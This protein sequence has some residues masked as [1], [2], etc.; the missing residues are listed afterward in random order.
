VSHVERQRKRPEEN[1]L[2]GELRN[3]KPPN[4]KDEHGK[5]EEDEA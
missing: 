2:K 3:I 4:F 5:G 1:I